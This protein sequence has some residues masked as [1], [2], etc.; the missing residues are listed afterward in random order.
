MLVFRNKWQNFNFVFNSNISRKPM[1]EKC[2]IFFSGNCERQN[3]TKIREGNWKKREHTNATIGS[4]CQLTMLCRLT[5]RRNS[6]LI[7]SWSP[8]ESMGIDLVS[9][10]KDLC[11]LSDK[12]YAS[13]MMQQLITVEEVFVYTTLSFVE[14][15]NVMFIV[16]FIGKKYWKHSGKNLIR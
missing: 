3:E 14:T 5:L 12:K 7:D 8:R 16:A 6:W 15:W 1:D 9:T 2:D 13:Q 11:H 4:C 10:L